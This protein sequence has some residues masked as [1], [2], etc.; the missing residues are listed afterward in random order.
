MASQFC[1]LKAPSHVYSATLKNTSDQDVT[2]EVQYAGSD[3]SHSET[4]E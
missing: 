4:V 1:G 2:V 3:S